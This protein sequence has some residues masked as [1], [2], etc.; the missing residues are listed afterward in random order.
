M[1]PRHSQ[2]VM[3]PILDLS[4]PIA[5]DP[6]SEGKMLACVHG[7]RRRE[8]PPLMRHFV[9]ICYPVKSPLKFKEERVSAM[10]CYLASYP[11][12]LIWCVF[13]ELVLLS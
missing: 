9:G 4:A 2:L 3:A 11:R 8:V 6:Y 13:I 12:R 10:E 1:G 5:L 7:E